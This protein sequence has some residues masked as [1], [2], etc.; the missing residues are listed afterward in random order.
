[1]SSRN[2]R[3]DFLG[4]LASYALKSLHSNDAFRI[5]Y[6]GKSV[7][8][9]VYG[10]KKP[11]FLYEIRTLLNRIGMCQPIEY[12]S[13]RKRK[14]CEEAYLKSWSEKGF[15]V[16]Q[17]LASPFPEYE[18]IPHLC[19]T[20]VEGV[21]LRSILRKG[22]AS[23]REILRGFFEDLSSRHTLAFRTKDIFLFH[24]DANTQNI[25]VAEKAFYHVDFEM[26]RPWEQPMECACREIS[27]LL[28]SMGEDL[29]PDERK[30]L[31]RLF[32]S[33]YRDRDVLEYLDRS[34]TRRPFQKLHRW[35]NEKKKAK[36][37]QRV[38]LYDLVDALQH[39]EGELPFPPH[40]KQNR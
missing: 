13:P 35:R 2:Q 10:P 22:Y 21:T 28:V 27:K 34:V 33:I 38:T 1:M 29:N 20:F 17:V 37:P 30:P 23:S 24:I 11:R 7:F 9:K 16:P 32:K 5:P 39:I 25:L 12:L 6:Q 14:D 3:R 15:C 40:E 26:G 19:T 18:E 36:N 4:R 8:V 31:Y